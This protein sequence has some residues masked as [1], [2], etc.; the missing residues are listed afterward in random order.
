MGPISLSFGHLHQPRRAINV[1]RK[2]PSRIS[3]KY[4]VV[5][6]M[7]STV[8]DSIDLTAK[9][10]CT[11][12]NISASAVATKLDLHAGDATISLPFSHEQGK[13]LSAAIQGIMETFAAKQQAAR[14]KR[15]DCMDFQV[16][17]DHVECLE[18]VCNPNAYSTAFEA[19]VFITL[20]LN[21]GV[22]LVTEGKLSAMKA[23]VELFLET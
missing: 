2:Q 9:L 7:H 4:S 19:K 8:I 14:P 1:C 6:G 18:I 12:S 3:H 22:K 20:K 17:P 23:D 15:W 5:R 13:Q 10:M 16:S 11:L 21:G